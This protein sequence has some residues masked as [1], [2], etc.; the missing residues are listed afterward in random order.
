[1]F[2]RTQ[3]ISAKQ[4]VGFSTP[5]SF[6]NNQTAKLWQTFMGRRKDILNAV[7]T[8]LYSLQIYPPNFEP[9]NMQ[10]TFQKYALCQVQDFSQIPEGMLG[11]TLPAGLYAVFL[12]IGPA[13]E[14][15]KTFSYI[16]GTWLPQA[17]YTLDERPH[18]EVLGEKYKNNDPGSEEEI[19]I[20]I[21]QV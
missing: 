19:W 7:G 1:M 8:D 21:A 9:S 11:F 3:F 20:P 5:T 14:G 10:Q 18:F 2:L 12:H 17:G 13:S 15:Y 6:A 4:M 16:F